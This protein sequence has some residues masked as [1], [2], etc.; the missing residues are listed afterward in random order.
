MR[1][2]V[3]ADIACPWCYI[4]ERRLKE[5]LARRPEV[6]AEVRWWP[7]QL[8]PGFPREGTAWDEFVERKFGGWER[9]RGMFAHVSRAGAEDGIRFDF[10]RVAVAP[11]TRDAHRVMLL[12]QDEG[13]L[14]EAAEALFAGYFAEGR[15]VSDPSVL[16]GLAAA[17]GLDAARARE[18]LAGDAYAAEVDESQ[19]VA[20]RSGISGVPFFVFDE[21]YAVSGAQPVDVL[22]Q[23]IDRTLSEA[24]A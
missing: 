10:E 21:R 7:F 19:R 20:A 17:A 11:N 16:A 9:A 3:F 4:G 6:E 8:Q 14:W 24:A 1:I 22:L 15:N 2:D 12:A 23:V 18:V 5:A 13:K